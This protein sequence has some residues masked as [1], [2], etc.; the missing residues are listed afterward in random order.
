MPERISSKILPSVNPK[1]TTGL[2]DA[3]FRG[4]FTSVVMMG[5]EGGK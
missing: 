1:S 3:V 2:E 4:K 5:V